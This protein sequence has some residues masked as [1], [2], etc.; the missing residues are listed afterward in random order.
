ME[1]AQL[2]RSEELVTV[3]HRGSP[4]R[5]EILAI[6]TKLLRDL[7][8]EERYLRDVTSHPRAAADLQILEP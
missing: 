3:S 2:G 4:D 6:R 1:L 7:R 8:K 5:L